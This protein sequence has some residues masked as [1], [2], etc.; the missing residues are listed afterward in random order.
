MLP[1]HYA[2]AAM[3]GTYYVCRLCVRYRSLWMV[4]VAMHIRS[5]I[6][7]MSTSGLSVCS[8]LPVARKPPLSPPYGHTAVT[9]IEHCPC[10]VRWFI[11][12]AMQ[13]ATNHITLVL[14]ATSGATVTAWLSDMRPYGQRACEIWALFRSNPVLGLRPLSPLPPRASWGSSQARN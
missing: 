13:P 3:S 12:M 5:E 4:I 6:T 1:T 7:V 14:G 8:A 2:Q 10:F 11:G 9:R